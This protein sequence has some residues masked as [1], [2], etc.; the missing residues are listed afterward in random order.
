V[1]WGGA[2]CGGGGAGVVVRVGL[3]TLGTTSAG[4][5]HP[6][7]TT[8]ASPRRTSRGLSPSIND[9]PAYEP[10]RKDVECTTWP[11]L[12]AIRELPEGY[13][14]LSPKLANIDYTSRTSQE[15]SMNGRGKKDKPKD[16]PAG[17]EEAWTPNAHAVLFRKHRMSDPLPIDRDRTP[18]DRGPALAD[19]AKNAQIP[20]FGPP[21]CLAQRD[22]DRPADCRPRGRGC[23]ATFTRFRRRPDFD[24]FP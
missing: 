9:S 18:T 1:G 6:P 22:L 14:P 5:L 17:P 16:R 2:W 10:F 19:L 11:A 21:S 15:S 12:G 13:L 24:H 23:F 20:H 3:G 8:V 7:A 4:L